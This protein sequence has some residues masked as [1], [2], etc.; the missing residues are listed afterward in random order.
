LSTIICKFD[1]F[2]S[3]E[4]PNLLLLAF[5][6]IIEADDRAPLVSNAVQLAC[7]GLLPL[8]EGQDLAADGFQVTQGRSENAAA[9]L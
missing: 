6:Q 9:G 7:A 4:L 2:F 3:F 5:I 8:L 1:G